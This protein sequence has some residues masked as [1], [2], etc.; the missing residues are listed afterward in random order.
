[1]NSVGTNHQPL[2]ANGSPEEAAAHLIALV[3]ELIGV[4]VEENA[5]LSRGLPA[6]LSTLTKRKCEL[7]DELE[8][9]VHDVGAK[10]LHIRNCGV[11]VRQTYVARIRTL[12]TVMDENVDRLRSAIDAS[13]RRIDAV[14]QAIRREVA[15]T[16]SYSA[17]GRAC[18]KS[19]NQSVCGV[20]VSA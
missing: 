2:N 14:M 8:R 10:K 1:M 12:R 13:R 17:D 16:S 15:P 11:A 6:S 9:W 3:D 5:M 7:A 20:V 4:I 18:G 19:L